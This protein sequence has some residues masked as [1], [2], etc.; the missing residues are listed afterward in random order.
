MQGTGR[1]FV[2]S[3]CPSAAGFPQEAECFCG[4]A[5]SLP[6]ATAAPT[7]QLSRTLV[8]SPPAANRASCVSPH[9]LVDRSLPASLKIGAIGRSTLSRLDD[10]Q[11]EWGF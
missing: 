3:T 8:G 10:F 9:P 2:T 1:S 4:D 7:H 6:P 5:V 11:S